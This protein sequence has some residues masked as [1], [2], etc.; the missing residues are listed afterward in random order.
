[1]LNPYMYLYIC[2]GSGGVFDCNNFKNLA[3]ISHVMLA[4]N[5]PSLPY[6]V[7]VLPLLFLSLSLSVSHSMFFFLNICCDFYLYLTITIF[8][9]GDDFYAENLCSFTTAESERK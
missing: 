8:H 5:V 2:S 9:M 7:V 3:P 4:P 6:T 1:M